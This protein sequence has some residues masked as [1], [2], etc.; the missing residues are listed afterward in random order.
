M[1]RGARMRSR[2]AAADP[3]SAERL[4][5]VSPGPVDVPPH[6]WGELP[7]MHHRSEAFERVLAES[8][9]AVKEALASKHPVH[10]LSASGTGAM[11]AAVANAVPAG[12]R[13]AVVSCGKFGD[14]WA[15]IGTAFG[16]DVS[17]MRIPDGAAV[18]IGAVSERIR[19][20]RPP[21]LALTHVESSTGTLFPLAAFSKSLDEPRP[22][23][24]VDA[25]SSF[26]AEELAMDAWGISVIVGASQKAIGAPVGVSFVCMRPRRRAGAGGRALYYFDLER[27]RAESGASV[28]PF[29]PAIA[30]MQ[31]VHRSLAAMRRVGF[32][33]VRARHRRAGEAFVKAC[34]ALGL[35]EYSAAPAAA[36]QVLAMPEG[37]RSDD[38]LAALERRGFIAAN[39]QGGLRGKVIRTGFLG[40]HDCGTL[41]RL[42]GA[43]GE[44]IGERG[45][46][47]DVV[48]AG[49]LMAEYTERS[50]LFEA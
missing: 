34:G 32:E 40:L 25:I 8:E 47:P 44:S 39:G 30:T 19:R 10:F 15:E 38:I 43:L 50:P 26:G 48:V 33:N 23:I 24:L 21:Y 1:D 3:R 45:V 18:D 42:V 2:A 22:A 16:C 14:R 5:V 29:T 12:E 27:Y 6:V 9:A 31:L 4:I 35:S 28:A 13:L 36:V 17:L 7:P 20:E 11:E 37:V 49:R 41:M 46:A